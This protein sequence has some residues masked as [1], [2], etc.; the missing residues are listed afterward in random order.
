MKWREHTGY[1][2][3]KVMRCVFDVKCITHRGNPIYQ[4]FVSQKPP[5][6]SSLIRGIA[7]ECIILSILTRK[8]GMVGIKDIRVTEASGSWGTYIVSIQK[9]YTSQPM[10]VACALLSLTAPRAGKRVII[11]DDDVDVQSDWDVEWALAFRVRWDRDF[12]VIPHLG[13]HIL[14]PSVAQ[15]EEYRA[16]PFHEWSAP[17]MVIDATKKWP[18]PPIA[19][20]PKKYLDMAKDKWSRYGLPGLEI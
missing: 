4:A 19:L 13:H 2:A 5:S 12:A 11:V 3:P 18:Y 14:V 16:K 7:T 17:A 6:E 9:T 15:Y 8:L 20:P 1:L 10:H